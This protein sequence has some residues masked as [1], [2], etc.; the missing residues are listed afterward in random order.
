MVL[1]CANPPTPTAP[2][3]QET[4]RQVGSA[5]SETEGNRKATRRQQED[6][7]RAT[8]GQLKISEG[9]RRQHALEKPRTYP[10]ETR[11]PPPE[12]GGFLGLAGHSN[13]RRG[14]GIHAATD[15]VKG[16]D[17]Q[18][19]GHELKVDGQICLIVNV[20]C[21]GEGGACLQASKRKA[22][23]AELH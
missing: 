5:G 9:S 11:D 22:A 6:D 20:N 17:A 15:P 19:V 13:M 3:P 1:H 4:F 16:K 18:G 7:K 12:V 23:G 8:A 21:L 14:R 10:D 2:P